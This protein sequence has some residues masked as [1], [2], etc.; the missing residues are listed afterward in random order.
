M[1]LPQ[2]LALGELSQQVRSLLW[3]VLYEEL[4]DSIDYTAMYRPL[5][6][7]WHEIMRDWH[8]LFLKGWMDEYDNQSSTQIEIAK[9]IVSRGAYNEV[10]DFLQFI[11]RH[12]RKP[13]RIE[14]TIRNLLGYG[15]AAYTVVDN[16][17]TIVPAAT[18]EEGEAVEKVFVDLNDAGIPGGRSHLRKAAEALN[19]GDFPGSVRESIHAVESVAKMLDQDADKTLSPALAAL[20]GKGVKIHGALES[21]F[22]SIYGYTSDE[23]GVRHALLEDSAAVDVHDAAFMIGACSSF[24]S[25]LIGKARNAGIMDS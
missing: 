1:P 23:K 17:W 19:N 24:I 6:N 4:K 25:Y 13:H 8:V 16:G 12:P 2:R 22:K 7:P 5:E 10:F 21:G 20:K 9:T 11:L 18:P 15:K 14:D 3:G